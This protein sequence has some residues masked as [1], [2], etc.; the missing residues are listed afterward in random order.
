M[1]GHFC[2]VCGLLFAA[3]LVCGSPYADDQER[4][5]ISM[6]GE[7]RFQLDPEDTGTKERWFDRVMPDTIHLPGS[8]AENGYGDDIDVDTKWT[9][10]FWNRSWFTDDRFAKYRQ[11]GSVKV[12]FWLQPR[13]HY[14]G[15]AWYQKQVVI[16]DGWADRK[17]FLLLERCHWETTVWVDDT[18]I[19]SQNSLSVPHEYDLS[20]V[21]TPG[22]HTVTLRV[23]NTV[24]IEVG[25][26]A[27]SVSDNTQTNW[28]GVI[29][30]LELS[31]RDRLWIR[32]VQIFPDVADKSATVRV[33]IGNDTGSDV[34]GTLTL[35]AQSWNSSESQH[36]PEELS[37]PIEAGA[38]DRT[39]S[40]E[41]EYDMG[42][43]VRL[44]SEF[45]PVTEGTQFTINGRKTFVRGTLE[46]C[47]FPLTGY[48]PTDV[49]GWI[50]RLKVARAHGLNHLRFHSWCPS[51]AAFEAAD[52]M[53]FTYQIECA[54]WTRIGDGK[55]IDRF[56]YDEGDRIMRAYGN[57]PSFA[58]MA[59]GNEPSGDNQKRFLGDLLS[60][61]QGKDSRRLYVSGAG[62]PII[63]EN[64]YHNVP[65][66]RV[67]HWGAGLHS[68]F[69]AEPF[70]TITDYRDYVS[71]FDV[72]VIS[73]EIGQWCA[74][75][76]FKEI[77]KYTGVLQAKN[78]EVFRETLQENHMLDQAE[79]FLM[80]SGKLQTMC[81][82]ED[83][84]AALRT[85]GFGGFHLLDLHDFPGQGTALVGV[86]DAFW[87]SKG[88]VSPEEFHR[89]ACETV[90][91]VR[92]QKCV[93]T[94]DEMFSA[95]VEVAHF[96]PAPLDQVR[97]VWS[98]TGDDGKVVASGDLP[99]VTVPIGN[100]F[101]LGWIGVPLSE[102]DPPQKLVLTVALSDTTYTNSWDVWVYPGKVDTAVP[103]GILVAETLDQ[104]V[105]NHLERGGSVLML[106]AP[107]TVKGDS[108]GK[109]PAGF[110]PIFWNTFWTNNQAPHTLGILCD[111]DHPALADFPTEFHSNWQWWDL[112][113]GSQIMIMNG[114]PP[115][116]RPVVQVIDDWHWNRRLGLV[117]EARV[118]GGRMLVCGMDI[119]TNLDSRP[120]ARQMRYSLL[121]Y[122]AS[123]AF[124]PS[125][126]LDIESLKT[127]FMDMSQ[128]GTQFVWADSE[129]PG[130][131]GVNATD[132]NPATIWHTPWKENA[133][134][135]PHEIRVRLAEETDIAGIRYLPRQ[136]MANGWIDEYTV[137]VSADGESWGKPAA[138]G[139]FEQGTDRQEVLF[140]K[141]RPGPFVRLVA[142]SAFEDKPYAAIAELEIVPAPNQ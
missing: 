42:D 66:P 95:R 1:S 106:P 47:I 18:E 123:E 7:W 113:H 39:V 117:L 64:Q 86:V 126:E 91:L 111:P 22:E 72:P 116:L 55:P 129:T 71:R 119:E 73:H 75:P 135:F 21:M 127:L 37:V 17:V 76:N 80:A 54:A 138:R 43:D 23:D 132:G 33:E 13:K 68:R 65:E 34:N 46:C 32:D 115:D 100:A 133:P 36:V 51:E 92:M 29:G 38:R 25:N 82:K 96:G 3:A 10:N 56:I 87:D 58:F 103:E 69:N 4:S 114:L 62:W 2:I 50:K 130:N 9:G 70:A 77:E 134:G 44:W 61:W 84:E 110:S 85:P 6:A 137:Y 45:S 99:V 24:K 93:W 41:T 109:V 108:R 16:P 8:T 125:R 31:V 90:P 136:D 88:Y 124:A 11:P 12:T 53:G 15:P 118:A 142:R 104:D 63:P 74:Y 141:P 139:R 59:Y 35:A 30:K 140:D 102:I 89:F 121:R 105:L 81:Y 28:N 101:E 131:E 49:D 78:F 48:P 52:R 112:V 98:L 40:I 26:D 27:H 83:I 94:T 128:V 5:T 97:P 19:G 60:Y 107:G 122:M 14:V 57:H 20:D 120:V 79:D 67:Q